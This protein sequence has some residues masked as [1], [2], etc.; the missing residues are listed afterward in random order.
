MKKKVF[1]FLGFIFVFYPFFWNNR[2]TVYQYLYPESESHKE[3][4]ITCDTLSQLA[5][6]ENPEIGYTIYIYEND[7]LVPYL[8][9]ENSYS[10]NNDTLLLRKYVLKEPLPM[11]SEDKHSAFYSE[12][13]LDNYLNTDFLTLLKNKENVLLTNIICW[14][15]PY[16]KTEIFERKIFLLSE[17]ESG[18]HEP[19]VE[20]GEKLEYFDVKRSDLNKRRIAYSES[21]EA[22]RWWLR[23]PSTVYGG[24]SCFI[25]PEGDR[26]SAS[27]WQYAYG[28]R[29][30]FCMAADTPITKVEYNGEQIYVIEE[31]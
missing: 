25:A 4:V 30:A 21:G 6:S 22:I 27:R 15:G 18:E 17:K 10:E 3:N 24:C 12:S 23:T 20:E 11:C 7:I 5:Y 31:T 8:V 16:D 28:V 9:L 13:W 14:V 29:P 1:I 2:Y 19:W 26:G